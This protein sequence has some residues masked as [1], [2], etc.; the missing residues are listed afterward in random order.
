[1]H[2][3]IGM[4]VIPFYLVVS[5][6][7]IIMSYDAVRDTLYNMA[8]VQKPQKM[9]GLKAQG[10][11]ENIASKFDEY[12]KA[13]DLFDNVLQKNYSNVTL[14]FPQNG[15][16]YSF[17]YTDAGEHCHHKS[18]NTLEVDINTSSVLKHEIFEDKSVGEKL[19]K[20][21]LPLH[22]GDFFGFIGKVGMFLASLM[23]PLFVITGLMLYVKRRKKKEIKG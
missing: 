16:V 21:I 17:N 2:S 18:I 13:I 3:A 4:W 14:R 12:Q 1:M 10:K 7:G 6:T 5:L 22:T 11:E 8:G 23:M 19:L 15:T 20:N 9:H